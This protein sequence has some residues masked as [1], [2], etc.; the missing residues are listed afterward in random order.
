MSCFTYAGS[1]NHN[2]NQRSNRCRDIRLDP[3]VS[4]MNKSLS[5]TTIILMPQV[6]Q[7]WRS[8]QTDLTIKILPEHSKFR[9]DERRKNLIP[10]CID[11]VNFCL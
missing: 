2:R 11:S 8:H 3:L 10:L 4:R 5:T 1:G 6:M 7:H 9:S